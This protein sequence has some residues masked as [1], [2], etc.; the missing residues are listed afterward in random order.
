MHHYSVDNGYRNIVDSKL[1]SQCSHH[2]SP[3][4]SSWVLFASFVSLYQHHLLGCSHGI[5][6]NDV[7]SL[8][9][10]VACYAL[11]HLWGMFGAMLARPRICQIRRG[12]VHWTLPE[13]G[14]LLVDHEFL[15]KLRGF[16]FKRRYCVP[17]NLD[18]INRGLIWLAGARHLRSSLRH[19]IP[20]VRRLE[21]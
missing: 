12:H 20:C 6:R 10:E 4:A 7:A 19:Y 21:I 13:S 14:T 18:W 17:W 16:M 9:S 1:P 11:L 5:M 8:S 15:V 2:C 3:Q